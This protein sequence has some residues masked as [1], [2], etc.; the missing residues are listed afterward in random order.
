MNVPFASLAPSNDAAHGH[1]PLGA[2]LELRLTAA[3]G[4]CGGGTGE[5]PS[6]G[7]PG[8]LVELG[9]DGPFLRVGGGLEMVGA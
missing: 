2:T 4:V 6:R 9:E 1:A 3:G 7:L 8:A 5:V